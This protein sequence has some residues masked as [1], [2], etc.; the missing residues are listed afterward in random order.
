MA[1]LIDAGTP[2]PALSVAIYD[3][4]GAGITG[5]T[6]TET[7][8]LTVYNLGNVSVTAGTWVV[9]GIVGVPTGRASQT[10][11]LN[12]A[13]AVGSNSWPVQAAYNFNNMVTAVIKVLITTTIYLNGMNT[14]S[15]IA[16]TAIMTA[17]QIK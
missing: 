15:A 5:N 16:A 11:Y 8:A 13:S 1:T 7:T 10:L 2:G 9:M 14:G 12:T 4:G 3:A 6:I 17:T